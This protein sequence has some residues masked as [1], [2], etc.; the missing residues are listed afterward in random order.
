MSLIDLVKQQARAWVSIPVSVG[1][2]LSS[3]ADAAEAGVGL[4]EQMQRQSAASA[5]LLEAI[6]GPVVRLADAFDESVVQQVVD[7][8]GRLPS[9][10]SQ[11]ALVSSRVESLLTGLESPLRAL[12]PLSQALDGRRFTDMIERIDASLPG[13]VRLPETE[14]EVQLLRETTDRLYR[15]V[16]EVQGRF[17]ALPGA[18]LF[19]GAGLLLGRGH[20]DPLRSALLGGTSSDADR[21]AADLDLDAD[22]ETS[23]GPAGD[24]ATKRSTAAGKRG[25]Q[26]ERG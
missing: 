23:S 3:A 17:A 16:D 25:S 26:R 14:N 2:L 4:L 5:R 22:P 24:R 9:I 18:G 20:R 13:L 6:E 10:V 12:G 11:T 19:P 8:L 15:L 7:A 1:R 21:D